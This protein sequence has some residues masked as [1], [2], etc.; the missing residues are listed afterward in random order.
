M[1][2]HSKGH[3]CFVQGNDTIFEYYDR[4]GQ[5]YR[6]PAYAVIMTDGYRCGRWECSKTHLNLFKDVIIPDSLILIG[7]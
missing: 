5:I 4:E 3:I 7:V 1:L 2:E 6:A